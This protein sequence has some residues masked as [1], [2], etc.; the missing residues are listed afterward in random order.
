MSDWLA[1]VILG[2]VEGLTEFLPISSTGHLLLVEHWM[3]IRSEFIRS[4]IMTALDST[5]PLCRGSGTMT[6]D[7]LKHWRETAKSHAVRECAE[8]HA[9][10]IECSS[11]RTHRVHRA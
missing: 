6:P 3:P 11:E 4:A 7:Q 5:C 10:T 1:V 2:I 9:L 8:C